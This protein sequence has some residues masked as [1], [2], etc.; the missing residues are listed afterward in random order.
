M[1]EEQ[2]KRIEEAT[3]TIPLQTYE[4]LLRDRMFL[5]ALEESGVDNW[6]FYADALEN[7]KQQIKDLT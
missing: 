6:D 7:Y 2:Q 1:T 4:D 5:R 3:V